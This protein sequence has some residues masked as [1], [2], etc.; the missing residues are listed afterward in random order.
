MS[1]GLRTLCQSC[2][3]RQSDVDATGRI[4]ILVWCLALPAGVY[5]LFAN[6]IAAAVSLG[7]IAPALMSWIIRSGAREDARRRLEPR[8]TIQHRPAR[9]AASPPVGPWVLGKSTTVW[10]PDAQDRAARDP[11][12]WYPEDTTETWS[13]RVSVMLSEKHGMNVETLR[14]HVVNLSRWCTPKTGEAFRHWH[15]RAQERIARIDTTCGPMSPA[16]AIQPNET[17]HDWLIRVALL[18]IS[19]GDT[20]RLDDLVAAIEPVA[21]RDPPRELESALDWFERVRVRV[22]AALSTVPGL[23]SRDVDA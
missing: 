15:T 13:R 4:I 3:Q 7:L 12:S 11:V 5:A 16:S 23:P 9:V 10:V 20:A 6:G 1:F 19:I 2:A 21:E 17:R 18:C 8:P 14:E 22:D